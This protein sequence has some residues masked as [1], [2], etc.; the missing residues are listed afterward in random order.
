MGGG[1][2]VYTASKLIHDGWGKDWPS[3]IYGEHVLYKNRNI[4]G[5]ML[6]HLFIIH[7]H[8]M[9]PYDFADFPDFPM[10]TSVKAGGKGKL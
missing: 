3:I 2:G 7:L 1:G 5:Q 10:L 4:L 8:D 9:S 6:K